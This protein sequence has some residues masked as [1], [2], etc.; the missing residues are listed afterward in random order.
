MHII[1]IAKITVPVNRQRQEF[2]ADS[3]VQLAASIARIGLINPLTV[4]LNGSGGV[5]LRAGERRLRAIKALELLG[6]GYRCAGQTV[7]AGF[8]ACLYTGELSQSAVFEIELEENIQRLDLTWQEKARAIEQLH[9]LRSVQ[10]PEQTVT[11]TA[12]E[13]RERQPATPR[14]D[15]VRDLMIARHLTDPEVAKA[16]DANEATKII[17]RKEADRKRELHA[18]VVGRT[19][20][21]RDHTLLLGDCCEILPGFAPNTF[22]VILSD[23]PYGMG[24]D[25]FGDAAGKMAGI[26][27]GYSDSVD[28]V[29]ALLGRVAPEITRVAR[30]SAHL[31]L[32]CDID[33]FH[34]L[35]EL[36]TA[37]GWSV[38]R[39]PLINYKRGSGRV[40]LPEHGPRR[41]WEPILYAYRGGKKCNAIYSDVIESQADDNLGHGAQKPVN[42]FDNLL[43]RSVRAGDNILDPFAGTGTIFEA[44]HGLKCRATGIELEPKYFGLAAQRIEGL[45]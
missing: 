22:D 5:V 24:A 15:V 6:K 44:A 18:A 11:M 26:T 43:R 25:S 41:Q 35:K 34:W 1:P 23:P 37:L 12:N 28:D 33:Q 36:F 39:T 38:F 10:N 45:T 7:S 13:V 8:A 14:A 20:S 29:R 30:Q 4:D 17:L 42:L 2:D 27:H 31:Y 19:F 3:G 9:R 21:A 16:R 40:P 32:C